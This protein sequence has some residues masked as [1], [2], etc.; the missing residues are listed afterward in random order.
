[1]RKIVLTCLL[2][3]LSAFAQTPDLI[4][5]HGKIL[6]VDTKDTIAQAVAIRQ[7]NIL[8]VGSDEEI[9]H[10]AGNKAKVIDLHGRTATPGLIDSH[11]HLAQGGVDELYSVNLSDATTVA[12]VVNRVQAAAAKLKPG[13]WLTGAGWDEGKLADHRYI[14]ASDLDKASPHNPV[15]LMHT[16]GHYGVANHEALRL[17]HITAESKNPTAGTIDRDPQG[18]PTGVL[19]ERAM[20]VVVALI[21]PPT[22]EQWRNGI[23]RM[24]DTMHR[25]GMTG[26][27][28]PAIQQ[29]IWDAY[30]RLQQE[31]KLTIHVCVLWHG[32][33]TLESAQ[34]ALARIQS[35]PRPPNSFGDGNLLSCGAKL[36]MDG[37]GGARTAWVYQD[38]NKNSTEVDTG[39]HGYPLI[40]PAVYRQMVRLFHQAG[41]SVGTHAIGDHAIDWV[42]DT[43]AE[44]LKE[45][46]TPGLRHSIIHANIPTDHAI[47]TMASLQK[48]YDAGYPESQPPFTW[49]IGDTYAGNFGPQRVLRLNPFHTYLSQGIIWG[50][51][52]DYP[53]TPLPARYGLWSS[54]ERETARG[55]YGKQPFG[56]AESVD[57]HT[58]LR[59]YTAWAARQL[60]LEDKVGTLE[61]GKQ[62]DIAVWDRDLYSI[63]TADLR[64]LKCEMTIYHGEVVYRAANTPVT[65]Q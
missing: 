28:D 2:S 59:S 10:L 62:A 51:G 64:D 45:K 24:V 26:V 9:L 5:I 40:D 31:N 37:S 43:Y 49:W 25:E 38:W 34:V 23:L 20:D 17:A 11:A 47:A 14:F 36:F 6:T 65:G 4:L 27:K 54:V 63:P 57:V 35:L 15:W 58:A 7:G 60:F 16:T 61:P 32:G 52:S 42:V 39:N 13:E 18:V 29:P 30:Y 19:K 41:V 46:P 3:S 55:V 8:A 21:P 1:M 48:T 56:T 33:T 12:Q 50:G 53:V 44:V 22:P